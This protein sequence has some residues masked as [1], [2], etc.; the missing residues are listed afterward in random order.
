M[1]TP[2]SKYSSSKELNTLDN[3]HR[4]MV[5]IFN[6]NKGDI[7]NI[8]QELDN[9]KNNLIELDKRIDKFNDDDIR[10]KAL[11]LKNKEELENRYNSIQYNYDEM[12]YY[13]NAG[14]LILNYYEMRDSQDIDVKESKNILEF[15]CNKKEKVIEIK[16]SRANLFLKTGFPIP[17]V[18]RLSTVLK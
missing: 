2:T 8:S 1:S 13:D 9:I 7:N 10:M 4:Q 3:K 14:D 15:L 11:L 16:N 18:K 17:I 5:K 6:N 12:D